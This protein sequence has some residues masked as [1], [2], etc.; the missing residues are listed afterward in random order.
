[1]GIK[2]FI[3]NKIIESITKKDPDADPNKKGLVSVKYTTAAIRL[4]Q[5]QL[6]DILFYV[7][8][9]VQFLFVGYYCYLLYTNI[10]K[11]HF[12]ILYS[13]LIG[14]SLATFI[15][16]MTLRK[17]QN[18][19]QDQSKIK[20]KRRK[21]SRVLLKTMKYLTK[22]AIIILAIV[23]IIKNGSTQMKVILAVLSIL[24]LI[25]QLIVG[26]VIRLINQYISLVTLAVEEDMRN[27]SLFLMFN[28]E[29]ANI[30]EL[31][32]K[33]DE[34]FHE[35]THS[36][37]HIDTI[38]KLEA[39]IEAY[40]VKLEKERQEAEARWSRASKILET[41]RNEERLKNHYQEEATNAL[42]L[43]HNKK[44]VEHVIHKAFDIAKD[45]PHGFSGLE[46][47]EPFIQLVYSYAD[48]QYQDISQEAVAS[49]LGCLLFFISPKKVIPEI[50]FGEDVKIFQ[51]CLNDYKEAIDR[52]IEWRDGNKSDSPLIENR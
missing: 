35:N 27:S 10:Q 16:E 37:E 9:T 6:A 40:K 34:V 19:N 8:L 15:T 51:L 3:Q 2:E 14:V 18:D 42:K 46:Y 33:A 4:I 30:L 36:E 41:R 48:N 39:E 38:H 47:L 13:I 29:K 26:V 25:G 24:I 11:P 43:I 23:D 5:K 45:I 17:R 31:N 28:Q 22:V 21:F 7:N 44:K 49:V 52:F 12:I 20:A 32:E 1:M 50:V